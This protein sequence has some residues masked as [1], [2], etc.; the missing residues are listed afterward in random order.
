MR[1]VLVVMQRT[2]KLVK[3]AATVGV[4][5]AAERPDVAKEKRAFN[6]RLL[7]LNILFFLKTRLDLND[8]G[9]LFAFLGCLHQSLDNR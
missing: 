4:K 7:H 3:L 2:Q 9:H 5:R 1:R 6:P 8:Y